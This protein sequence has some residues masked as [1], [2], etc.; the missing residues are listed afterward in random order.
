MSIIIL[1]TAASC[2]VRQK[3]HIEQANENLKQLRAVLSAI[4]A[5]SRLAKKNNALKS[6]KLNGTVSKK[7]FSIKKA[8]DI[9]KADLAISV[10]LPREKQTF[11]FFNENETPKKIML[12]SR[13]FQKETSQLIE[14]YAAFLICCA[15]RVFKNDK[16]KYDIFLGKL[17]E[18]LEALFKENNSFRF[19][20]APVL[21]KSSP[22]PI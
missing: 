15:E 6:F 10:Y 20:T 4:I 18:F 19:D 17:D 16:L 7:N 9:E 1:R 11:P 5:L 21:E 14:N 22:T 12:L 3:E 13:D 8:K 2:A